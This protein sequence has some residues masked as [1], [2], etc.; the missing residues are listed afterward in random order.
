MWVEKNK[1]IRILGLAEGPHDLGCL[2]FQ[3]SL[4]ACEEEAEGLWS[5][6]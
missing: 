1:N 2:R 5:L 6:E 4:T 3:E